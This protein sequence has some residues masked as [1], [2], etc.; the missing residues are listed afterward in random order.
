MAQSEPEA[1]APPVD[2]VSVAL[3][4]LATALAEM[5]TLPEEKTS[6]SL[7]LLLVK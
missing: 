5:S 2:Q 7:A 1:V 3:E 4:P 6:A